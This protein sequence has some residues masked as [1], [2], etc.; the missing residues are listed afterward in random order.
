MILINNK[1]DIG[2]YLTLASRLFL[3]KIRTMENRVGIWMDKRIAFLFSIDNPSERSQIKSPIED[4]NPKGGS[5]SKTAYGP[6]ETIKEKSYLEREKRQEQKYFKSIIQK[7]SNAA[8][9]IVIGPAQ[10]KNNFAKFFKD[11]KGKKPELLK[12]D[13]ADSMTENQMADILR[14]MFTS[15][16]N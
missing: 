2:Q 4:F 10:T 6:V 7:V 14:R 11:Q 16:S 9:L 15:L 3:H 13:T 5:R 1:N 12:V 8:S